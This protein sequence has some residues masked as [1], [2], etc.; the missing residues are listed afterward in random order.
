MIFTPFISYSQYKNSSKFLYGASRSKLPYYIGLN[1]G[2][3][4]NKYVGNKDF[5][6]YGSAFA[7]G[8]YFEK[9]LGYR[10]SLSINFRSMGNYSSSVL[11]KEQGL[12]WVETSKLKSSYDLSINFN[13]LLFDWYGWQY[14]SSIGIGFVNN[15]FELNNYFPNTT[16]SSTTIIPL[17][18]STGRAL[19]KRFE[20]EIG[21]RYYLGLD[22]DIEGIENKNTFD[23]YAYAF[24]GLKYLIGEKDYRFQK[25]NSCPTVK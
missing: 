10:P 9:P 3:A 6:N 17:Q 21:Y 20:I 16:N 2:L 8:I 12:L 24:L 14:K 23:K 11:D 15:E 18:I 4:S 1:A 25:K 22:N 5:I 13:Y 19:I 7:W